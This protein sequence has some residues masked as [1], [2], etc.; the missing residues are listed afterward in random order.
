MRKET[1]TT[2]QIIDLARMIVREE[3]ATTQRAPTKVSGLLSAV[4]ATTPRIDGRITLADVFIS[5]CIVGGF[6]ICGIAAGG[7]VWLTGTPYVE[8]KTLTGQFAVSGAVIAAVRLAADGFNLSAVWEN[9]FGELLNRFAP[10]KQ[11]KDEHDPL[12][13]RVIPYQGPPLEPVEVIA[14]PAQGIGSELVELSPSTRTMRKREIRDFL[15]ESFR[16]E[17]WTRDTW[18]GNPA[19]GKPGKGMSQPTWN[20]LKKFLV[21]LDIWET[22]HPPSLWAFITRLGYPVTNQTDETN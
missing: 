9:T 2:E 17:D 16:L 10:Q 21:T 5:G 8:A 20:A 11:D 3:L 13:T 1:W 7:G 19:R 15:L 12:V 22:T 14:P 18:C 6:F 4:V